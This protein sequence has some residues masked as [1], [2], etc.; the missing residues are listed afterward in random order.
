MSLFNKK[1][2]KEKYEEAKLEQETAKETAEKQKI[3]AS[4]VKLPKGEDAQS[5]QSVIGP[6]ITEKASTL[7]EQ[8]KYVFRIT[9]S[10]NKTEVKKA[11]EKL[12]K[13]SVKNVHVITMPSKFRQVGRYKGRKPGFRKAIITLK[14]GD[15]IEI[16]G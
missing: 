2:K 15:R 11:I 14:K 5:Y 4:A 6:H 16:T 1:T 8:N 12:Y 3:A 13:V 9:S 10:A 7:G